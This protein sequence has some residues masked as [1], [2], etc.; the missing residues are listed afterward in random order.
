MSDM[1]LGHHL[2]YNHYPPVSLVFV[3]AA[4]Q[5]IE[6][7]ADGDFDTPVTM[8]NGVTLTAGEIVEQLHL[9]GFLDIEDES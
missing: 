1:W 9:D 6:H 8:A 5:A 3:P 2:Q 4:R 7:V